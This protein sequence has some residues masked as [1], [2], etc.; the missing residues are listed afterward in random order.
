[1]LDTVI[2]PT[3][4]HMEDAF[5]GAV[6]RGTRI[7]PDEVLVVRPA[8]LDYE[9][10]Q[11]AVRALM[12]REPSLQGILLTDNFLAQG[13]LNALRAA[14]RRP[15]GDVR[16]LGYGDT[17]FA[18][19]CSPKLSHYSLRLEEQVQFGLEALLEQIEKGE[20][21]EPRHALLPPLCVGCE[22]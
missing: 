19:H 22:T 17:V 8:R 5:R 3:T 16:V 6:S 20:T 14:G 21:Y 10:V 11:E 4:A 9:G 1:M 2:G 13:V 7:P 12:D 18:D 15:G